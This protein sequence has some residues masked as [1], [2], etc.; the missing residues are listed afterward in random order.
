[1]RR[2]CISL[3]R[4]ECDECNRIV[5]YPERFLAN[6]DAEGNKLRL[7]MEC[8]LKSGYAHYKSEKGATVLTLNEA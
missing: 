2:M 3:G 7:C 6:E 1:M 8:A 5:P 4:I